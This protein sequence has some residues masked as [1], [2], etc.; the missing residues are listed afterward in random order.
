M[1]GCLNFLN[2]ARFC[3]MSSFLKLFTPST[4]GMGELTALRRTRDLLKRLGLHKTVLILY[5][6]AKTETYLGEAFALILL[7]LSNSGVDD[8]L[9]SPRAGVDVSFGI[10]NFWPIST[11]SVVVT[12]FKSDFVILKR[13]Y[14]NVKEIVP[15][16]NRTLFD[17]S[18]LYS[19][20][21]RL[22]GSL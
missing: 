21:K 1:T 4:R 11:D 7:A 22:N 10:G 3:F 18:S 2:P 16:E 8:L 15:K 6:V 13:V 20:S 9:D 12:S 14:V 5:F 19:I 17:V